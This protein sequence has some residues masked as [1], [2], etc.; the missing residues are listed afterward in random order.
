MPWIVGIDEA[1]YGPNLGPLVM[2]SVACRVPEELAGGKLWNALRCAVRRYP[3]DEDDRVAVNDSK[4][5]YSA[6]RGLRDLETAVLATVTPWVDSGEMCLSDY[7]ERASPTC[8]EL[9]H[10]EPWY[11]GS[12]KLPAVSEP[13][14][15]IRAAMRFA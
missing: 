15:F 3:S 1:G 4:L 13:A 5:V 11:V 9:L 10:G 6:Q 14:T 12:S 7:V 2:T 8:H